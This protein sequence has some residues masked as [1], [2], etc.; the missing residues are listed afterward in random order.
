MGFTMNERYLIGEEGVKAY[1]KDGIICGYEFGARIP[2]YRGVTLSQVAHVR[3]FMDGK[4]EPQGNIRLIVKSGEEFKLDEILTV[5][6]YHW[7]Y[8]EKMRV[9]VLKDGGLSGG[10]HRLEVDIKI[11]VIYGGEEGFNGKA[12]LDFELSQGTAKKE[13]K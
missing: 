4:E 11:A 10:K 5:S 13:V 3:V 2:Y 8:G 12:Y 6:S 1:E 7:G 9:I